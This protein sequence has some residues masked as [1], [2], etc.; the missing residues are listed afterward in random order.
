MSAMENSE[1]IKA[2]L[3]IGN[4]FLPH[5]DNNDANDRWK[6]SAHGLA[7]HHRAHIFSGEGTCHTEYTSLNEGETRNILRVILINM[8]YGQAHLEYC[9]GA[10]NHDDDG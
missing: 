8:K 3:Q 6:D 1:K 10:I 7:G 2:S 5:G 9:S 4:V